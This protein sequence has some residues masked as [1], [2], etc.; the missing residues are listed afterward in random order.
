VLFRS[1]FYI[2]I[3]PDT[4]IERLSSRSKTPVEIYERKEFLERVRENYMALA[5]EFGFTIIDGERSPE[6]IHEDIVRR[7]ERFYP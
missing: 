1:V 7:L 6:E 4:A 3:S 2:D 5:K